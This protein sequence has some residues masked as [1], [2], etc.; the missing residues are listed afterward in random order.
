M[1]TLTT[2]SS[3]DILKSQ[4]KELDIPYIPLIFI[5]DGV[6]HEDHFDSDQ[7]Y[8]DFYRQ[9]KEGAMPTTSQI[10]EF[11]F[12]EFF[13]KTLAE[14]PNKDIIHLCLSSGVS[15]TYNNAL[16]AAAAVMKN[17]DGVKVY[18][19]DTLA[20]AQGLRLVLDRGVEL[21]NAGMPAAEAFEK[22]KDVSNNLHHWV[23]LE[24]LMHLK[25]G[26]RISAVKAAIG[27]M[28]KLKPIMVA[29]HEGN[30][31]V[32]KK[33]IGSAKAVSALAEGLRQYSANQTNPKVY[34]ANTDNDALV[35]KMREAILKEFPEAEI[36]VGWIGPVIGSH[37]GNNCI[38]IMFE[39]TG[40]IRIT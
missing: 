21:R 10:S 39:G 14:R 11:S 23:I 31:L 32:Y 6:A 24:N 27:T 34:I 9:L 17:H 7:E 15:G 25:R 3:C 5:I 18:I 2:D 13:E 8:I 20:A 16:N 26:G 28:I 36:V 33:V 40:R 19:V 22:L 1:F 35:E 38:A 12:E 37:L 4:L 29:N 30:L